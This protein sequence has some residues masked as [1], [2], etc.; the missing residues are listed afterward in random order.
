EEVDL[1]DLIPAHPNLTLLQ[2]MVDPNSTQCMPQATNLSLADAILHD[3]FLLSMELINST[4]IE[5]NSTF[6]LPSQAI[7]KDGCT[8]HL[9]FQEN[10]VRKEDFLQLI[11]LGGTHNGSRSTWR[12]GPKTRDSRIVINRSFSSVPRYRGDIFG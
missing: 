7:E 5:S 6:A 3:A 12:S 4:Q 2:L 1:D 8:G 9:S 10:Q 11:I